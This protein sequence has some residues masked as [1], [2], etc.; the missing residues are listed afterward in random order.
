MQTQPSLHIK[1]ATFSLHKQQKLTVE[2][3]TIQP[4]DFW[5]V[6]G[7]N[8]SGKTAFSLALQGKLSLYSG[9]Y[10]NNFQNI[11]LLSFEQQQK[12]IEQIF[13]DRNNDNVSPYDFGLT[14]RQVILNGSSK[15][16]LCDEYSEKLHISHLLERPFIQLSTGESRKVLFCQMLVSEPDLLILDEPFEGLDQQSVQY[17][18]L[19]VSELQQKMALVLIVNRFNDM[20]DA[21]DH[22]ALL[23]NLSLILQGNRAEIEQQAVY[24]QLK[25]A[26]ENVN[27]PLPTSA[28][29]LIALPENTNPFEL[30]DVNIQY[31]EK[32]IL[33]NLTWTV[34]PHQ[35]WWIKGP[36][37]AGKSTLLSII[38]GDH[39]QSYANKVRLFGRQRGTGE[40]IW[41]IKKNIGYVSSQ[42][43]MDYRVN[44]SALEVILS[45]FFNSIGVYQQVPN[46]LQLKAME[47]LERLNLAKFAKKPFRSLSWG[48][49]RL[50]LIT[51][52]MVKHPPI[53]ILDEPLQ[54]LDGINRKLVKQFIVQ[55]VTNSQTQLLFVSH[56]DSDAPNCITHLFEF[57]PKGET[58]ESG[59]EYRQ[60]KIK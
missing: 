1:N 37:G 42:L 8:G 27:V 23:D 50:L 40:T 58:N 41:E 56:Q 7:G 31:G 19:L 47:W 11:Q 12:I 28:A 38:T 17:W 2:N 6:V 26:E 60:L 33:D 55:L 5:V 46:A 4:H 24:S 18:M 21:A 43:H 32:K 14:A 35:H 13:N 44:C 57:V 22:I 48:Q 16:A 3:L 59:Y 25:F 10:E 30:E 54:G 34:E 53:L 29:P 9:E 39:P 51:R 36:N 45:G 15:T 52:A 20:P 49:Q